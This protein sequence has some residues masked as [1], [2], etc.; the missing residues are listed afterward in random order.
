[1]N[2]IKNLIVIIVLGCFSIYGFAVTPIDPPEKKDTSN[3]TIALPIPVATNQCSDS[4]GDIVEVTVYVTFTDCPDYDC[5]AKDCSFNICIYDYYYN[6]LD[7]QPFDPKECDYTFT[8]IR[9][10]EGEF[11]RAH[12]VEVGQPCQQNYYAGYPLSTNTVPIGGGNVY[13]ET[14]LCQD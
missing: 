1:M 13:I 5:E 4:R 12:L 14:H 3:L 2:F 8:G 10:T 6:L 7:C 11:L 9:A